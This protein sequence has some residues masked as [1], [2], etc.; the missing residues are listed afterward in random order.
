MIVGD[1]SAFAMRIAFSPK[2]IPLAISEQT[3]RFLVTLVLGVIVL[4]GQQPQKSKPQTVPGH[5][6]PLVSGGTLRYSTQR[7]RTL[8]EIRPAKPTGEKTQIL[9]SRDET[10]V[11]ASRILA[12][13][14]L[15]EKPTGV[16]VVTDRYASRPGPMSYCQAG[17]EQFVRVLALA[18]GL[19]GGLHETFSLK[20]E[21]CRSNLEL[22]PAGLSWDDASSAL[23]VDADQPKRFRV[24]EDGLV[25]P[26]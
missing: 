4:A 17:Q 6:L 23:T 11:P 16:Y 8:V 10:V 25:T 9:L 18:H 2:A 21:S 20:V 7:N 5:V 24:S 14:L 26:Y 15:A 3:A 1:I 19:K 13:E 22:G 12:F